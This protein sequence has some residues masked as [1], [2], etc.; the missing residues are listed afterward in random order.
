GNAGAA[1]RCPLTK[2]Q[3]A[4]P[5]CPLASKVG[6]IVLGVKGVGSTIAVYN[7]VPEKGYPAEFGFK[8]ANN[9]V[10]MYPQVQ[11]RTGQYGLMVS[12]PGATRLGITSIALTFY[13]VPSQLNGAGGAP[14]PF[15]SNQ[16]DCLI[17]Q[18]VSR[19]IVDSWQHPGPKLADGSPDLSDPRWKTAT[20]P[21][22][23]VTGCDE[24]SLASQFAPTISAVPTPGHGSTRVDSPSAYSVDLAFPQTNDPT[25]PSTTFDPA[26]PQAPQLK[27]TTVTLPEGVAI[28]PSAAGGLEGCSDLA[29][30]P[31]GDQVR[32]DST[33]PVTC[34]DASKVGTVTATSPLLAAH[35]AT[36]DAVTGAETLE[37]DVYVI[38]PHPGDFSPAGDQDGKVR[39][40]IQIDSQRY[41]LNAKLPGIATADQAHGGRL[42]ARFEDNPALPVKNLSLKFKAGDRAPLVN[43]PTCATG[44]TTTGLFTPWSRG[45]TRS[46]GLAV[47]GTPDVTA[48][49]AF[50]I[51]WDGQGAGC[52]G[53][54]PFGPV[55]NAGTVG[56][57]AGA[58]SPF[59]FDL[60]RQDREDVVN[61]LSVTLPGGLLAAVK[62][63]PLCS[64]ADANAGTCPAGS[65]VGSAQVSAGSGGSPFNIWDQPVALTGPYKGAPYGLA[66]AVHA[67]AGPFDLGTV[68][69]RQAL[70]INPDDAH[71]TVVSDPLP[72]I[73]DGVPLRV[74]RIHVDVDRPGFMRSPTSCAPKMIGTTVSSL[75]GQ[76]QD[77][78]SAFQVKD[79]DKL[80]FAPKLAMKLNG[81]NETKVGGHPGVE[82]L[83]TQEP[84]EAALKSATVTLPLSLALD[85]DNAASDSL[86]SFGDGLKDQCPES[87]VIGTVTAVS[88]LLKTPVSGKVFF[89]KGLRVDAKSGRLI[90]TLPTLLVELRGE[91]NLNLRATSDVPDGEHLVTTFPL[92]PDAAIS[93]FYLKL[94]GGK[95]G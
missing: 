89:V 52:P 46:D 66:I 43:P 22:P 77:R 37:G 11:P 45:G 82:A 64:D 3:P 36:T 55:V 4:F 34:P 50:D 47:L 53:T 54:L 63:V 6:S 83:V 57:Q 21:A 58:S 81:A 9:A 26:V 93:S 94:N 67:V 69:V 48:T 5:Q 38:K 68:V 49:S 12:V 31:K 85:P 18:P 29:S 35:D 86:C 24:P 80:P 60:T 7:L 87:S 72:T 13:G 20:A 88:P 79:C 2:L 32:L 95:K 65:R 75:G 40:L 33:V 23:P 62:D 61:G 78:L 15:L 92:V 30:D 17:A 59:S 28:S 44:A 71:V 74:R 90:K 42:T 51:S 84:G 56:Q 39:L 19:M 10:V 16:S 8:F 1:P 70:N 14:V 25:D 76:K 73:R 27:D 91:V 41:G